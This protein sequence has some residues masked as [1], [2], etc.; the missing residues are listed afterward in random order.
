M[1]S[2]AR[3]ANGGTWRPAHRNNFDVFSF[4]R[5][6]LRCCGAPA[7]LCRY[8]ISLLPIHGK[9]VRHH[10][11]GYG[12]GGAVAVSFLHF[13]LMNHRQLVALSRRQLGRALV[14]MARSHRLQ[15]P[16]ES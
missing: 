14:Q 12:K 11:A 7:I 8:E 1:I 3:S 5:Q 9:Q 6:L 4:P 16:L 2:F 13:S 10:L 15:W